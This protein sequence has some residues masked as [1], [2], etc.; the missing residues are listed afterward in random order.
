MREREREK[1][2]EE[3]VLAGASFHLLI[4]MNVIIKVARKVASSAYSK[5]NSL[6][7]K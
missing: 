3:R 5:V 1:E 7:S 6:K 4:Y 2:R